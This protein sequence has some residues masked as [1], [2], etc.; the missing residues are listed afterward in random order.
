MIT[1]PKKVAVKKEPVKEEEPTPAAAPAAAAVPTS[2]I[3]AVPATPGAQSAVPS[4]PAAPARSAATSAGTE[5]PATP[6]FNDPSA[7]AVGNA[8]EA[9]V[10]SMLEMGYPREQVDAA[11]RAAFNNP[12]RAVE[13]LLMGIPEQP[14]QAEEATPASAGS[15]AATGTIDAVT[16]GA[17]TETSFD[18][19]VEEVNL[20]EAAAAAANSSDL[21]GG[22][23]DG[24]V[25]NADLDALRASA[26]FQQMRDIVRQQPEMLEPILHQL[27]SQDPR[28]AEL[29]SSNTGAFVRML[30]EEVGDTRGDESMEDVEGDEGLYDEG[31]GGGA[32]LGAPAATRIVVTAEENE[33]ILRLI[34]L[35]FDR[36]AVIEAYFACDRDE[37][38]AANY[39]FDHGHDDDDF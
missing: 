17:N 3:A 29:I 12:D 7:F 1:K 36:H 32:P 11:M 18:A 8:R 4:T 13:Y 10:S 5:T 2:A 22:A 16:T 37:Q 26:Q 38:M 31:T 14:Q 39:L 20:F 21:D 25:R 30:E 35:G 33:A 27:V 15:V 19:P 24:R 23:D 9:A 28:L 34:Q 6:S